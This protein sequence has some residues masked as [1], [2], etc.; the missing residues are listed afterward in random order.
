VQAAKTALRAAAAMLAQ[1]QQ[2]A[3]EDAEARD[4]VEQARDLQE[5]L[6]DLREAFGRTEQELADSARRIKTDAWASAF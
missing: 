1:L 4:A 3:L 6:A 2:R 5:K